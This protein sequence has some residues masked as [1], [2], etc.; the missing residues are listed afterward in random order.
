MDNSQ[1]SVAED[2]ANSLQPGSAHN[3]PGAQGS[4]SEL[5]EPATPP[6]ACELCQLHRTFTGKTWIHVHMIQRRDCFT[7][8]LGDDGM[9][10]YGRILDQGAVL[11]HQAEPE[12]DVRRRIKVAQHF[13]MYRRI[14][15]AIREVDPRLSLSSRFPDFFL[16][17]PIPKQSFET[18]AITA[19][20][21][22]F[23]PGG[24]RLFTK[25]A[26]LPAAE[27]CPLI[28]P[29]VPVSSTPPSEAEETPR[30]PDSGSEV[31]AAAG[32]E[33]QG[34]GGKALIWTGQICSQCI[35]DERET[36]FRSFAH[37]HSP[38]LLICTS[39]ELKPPFKRVCHGCLGSPVHGPHPDCPEGL[40]CRA[41]HPI[42]RE[43]RSCPGHHTYRPP[44]DHLSI[45]DR[46]RLMLLRVRLSTAIRRAIYDSYR[47]QRA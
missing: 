28:P 34:R 7:I 10:Y 27:S 17:P 30:K 8:M 38:G 44:R 45:R 9:P 20:P 5:P 46:E 40:S 26:D 1:S 25:L 29:A 22:D 41:W 18:V 47:T 3:A 2:A 37:I 36:Q 14:D 16:S 13:K 19:L 31:P 6:A 24:F 23:L 32:S 12:S 35:R 11:Q 42:L 33:R 43:G 21:A 4:S 39:C 15:A